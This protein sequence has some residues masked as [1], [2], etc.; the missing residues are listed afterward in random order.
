ML[1]DDAPGSGAPPDGSEQHR[2]SPP[3]PAPITTVKCWSGNPGERLRARA[4]GR[5]GQ[6]PL[7]QR[8]TASERPQ[9]HELFPCTFP[10]SPSK[11]IERPLNQT[12][13]KGLLLYPTQKTTVSTPA[14]ALNIQPAAPN[15]LFTLA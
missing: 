15:L 14:R 1:T 8:Q 9:C 6:A 5:R 2:S 4:R 10:V 13:I 7:H 3:P 12:R 11:F